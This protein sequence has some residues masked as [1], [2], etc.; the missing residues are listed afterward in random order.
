MNN[1]NRSV[2]IIDRAQCFGCA[3][4]EKVCPKG[5]IKMDEN[6]E[7]FFYPKIDSS[8]VNCGLCLKHCPLMINNTPNTFSQKVFGVVLKNEDLILRSASGGV[9]VGIANYILEKKGVVYGCAYNDNFRVSHIGIESKNELYRL[10]GSKYIQSFISE[11]YVDVKTRL[12]KGDTVLYSG[13]PCQIA[14]LKSYLGRD[15][16][17]LYTIDLICHGIPSQKLFQ[18]YLQWLSIKNK[19]KI[20]YYSFRDKDV[21][22]WSCDG[23]AKIKTKK[24]TKIKII[25]GYCDPYY[26][27]FLRGET[28]RESCYVCKYANMKRIGDITIGDFWGV[29]KYY[30]NIDRSKGVSCCI[31][32]TEKGLDLFST[33]RERFFCFDCKKDEIA[34]ANSNLNYPTVRPKIRD[35]IYYGID[36]DLIEFFKTFKVKS[37]YIFQIKSFMSKITPKFV[38]KLL[39]EIL[40]SI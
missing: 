34:Y 1:V 9:F 40:R 14:G 38:K 10:Q 17:N 5:A 37:K 33:I 24:K 20:V 36:G 12:E 26:A 32:N 31:I 27:S 18:K 22:G 23:K 13:T 6:A 11:T 25:R 39:K 4:C 28:Y 35:K 30:S 16:K 15:Y 2:T 8:C 29:E 3:S 21:S 19:G 7:G